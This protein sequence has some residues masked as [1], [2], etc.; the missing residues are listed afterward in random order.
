LHKGTEV[1]LTFLDGD[2]DRPI[3]AG[4]VPNPET[5]SPVTSAN[6]TR[7]SI[8]TGRSRVDRS[9][10]ASE[11]ARGDSHN[12]RNYIEFEDEEN[13]EY[14]KTRSPGDL[15]LEARN[16][17]GEYHA[18]D[19]KSSRETGDEPSIHDLLDN[20]G[21]TYNPQGLLDRHGNDSQTFDEMFKNAHV[22]VSSLDTVNTQEGNIYDF[23]G[24]WNYNLGNSYV[25]E[26][27]NQSAK[28]NDTHEKDLL[29]KGGPYWT[30]VDW[31]KAQDPDADESPSESDIQIGTDKM[32][33]DSNGGTNVWV[34]KTFGNAYNY[35]EGNSIEVTKGDS[36]EIQHGGDHVE[37]SFRGDGTLKSWNRSGG[38]ISDEKKWNAGGDLISKEHTANG[39]TTTHKYCRDTGA[40][41]SYNSTHQGAN[42]VH[43]FDFNWAN[44][45]SAEF[46]FASSSSFSCT[47]A[48]ETSMDV[49]VAASFSLEMSASMD[50]SFALL[51]AG[52]IDISASTGPL[53]EIANSSIHIKLPGYE[54]QTPEPVKNELDAVTIKNTITGLK[55]SSCRV[56]SGGAHI[57]SPL[58]NLFG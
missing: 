7:S 6:Q 42:S 34:E 13:N 50:I 54:A 45:A 49:R 4:A 48:L 57:A 9:V 31:S 12:D 14:I 37:M 1:M 30:K 5:A 53:L 39:I 3:I 23:G 24:Y 29:N 41:L 8:Q 16:R 40:Q 52:K 58:L 20:F 11:Y 27:L 55:S 15:W 38:G 35:S 56:R 28:L 22:H 43:S 17:Y 10:G 51:A 26:H 19:Y 46:T 36:L 25:E 33:K 32:W 18:K 21:S 2:P 47:L 44:T